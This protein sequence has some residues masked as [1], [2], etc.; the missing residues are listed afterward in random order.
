M[1]AMTSS[2]RI[3][4]ATKVPAMTVNCSSRLRRGSMNCG[5]KAAKK[6]MPF[7]LVIAD[8]APWRNSDAPERGPDPARRSAPTG[9][10]R[11]T[12]MPSQTR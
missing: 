5:R 12:W 2:V 9:G 6:R 8:S 11:Q 1:V 10:E 3:S 7:G 4:T